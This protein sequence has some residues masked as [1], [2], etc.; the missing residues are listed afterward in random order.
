MHFFK[1]PSQYYL[2]SG[3]SRLVQWL[4]RYSGGLIKNEKQANLVL[5]SLTILL[6]VLS[7]YLMITQIKTPP[8]IPQ[9]EYSPY[10]GYGGKELPDEF[11]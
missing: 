4:I 9:T 1:K 10:E 3:E 6:F 7:L 8:S 5:I 11:R 2:Y